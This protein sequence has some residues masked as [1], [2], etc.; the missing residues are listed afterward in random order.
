[1]YRVALPSA[2][3]AVALL[4]GV[5]FL[6]GC[7]SQRVSGP[8]PVGEGAVFS[9]PDRSPVRTVESYLASLRD[10]DFK[11]AYGYVSRGYAANLD[12]ESY[13]LNMKNLL[14]K[15]LRWSLLDYEVKNVNIFGGNA[16]VQAALSVR[17]MPSHGGE[18]VDKE[19]V[20][21][22]TLVPLEGEWVIVADQC[23]EGC[24]RVGAGIEI[25][26]VQPLE[27]KEEPPAPGGEGR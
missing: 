25:E 21:Q 26:Q 13:E 9:L 22:Y 6:P 10:Y 2:L 27:L 23:V 8:P 3:L 17:Y 1:M 24:G 16:Y 20:V 11:R 4:T 12:R 15:T 19:F 7:V 14:L 5:L 18:P